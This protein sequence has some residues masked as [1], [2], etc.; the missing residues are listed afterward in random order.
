MA[1][2]CLRRVC[3]RAS[4]KRFRRSWWKSWADRGRV[5]RGHT[6]VWGRAPS[7]VEMGEPPQPSPP[8]IPTKTKTRAPPGTRRVSSR[9][10]RLRSRITTPSTTSLN[11]LRHGARSSM[12]ENDVRGAERPARIPSRAEGQAPEIWRGDRVS[13][14]RGWGRRQDYGTIPSLRFEEAGGEVRAAGES[15]SGE[16]YESQGELG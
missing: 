1:R 6:V 15:V 7:P 16:D 9:R 2:T 8:T 14:R 5:A 3:H 11:F 10:Q 4:W 13:A 12:S